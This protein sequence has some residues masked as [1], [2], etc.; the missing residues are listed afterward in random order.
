MRRSLTA[1]AVALTT[2][3]ALTACGGESGSQPGASAVAS[4]AA[5]NPEALAVESAPWTVFDCAGSQAPYGADQ[6]SVDG[7][8]GTEQVKVQDLQGVPF[9]YVAKDAAAVSELQ[10]VDIIEGDGPAVEAGGTVNVNYCGIGLTSRSIF[11]S[12]YSRGEPVPFPLDGVIAGFGQGL[13]GMKPG[14]QRLL[15][16]PGAMGYGENPP[17][18]IAPN[19]TLVFVVDL[20]PAS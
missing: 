15:V 20:L 1:V 17:P 10:S 8:S 4:S 13:I 12:S 2:C 18:G 16:I 7:L 3:L 11:D 19:E 14:G 5:T 6:A 9:V